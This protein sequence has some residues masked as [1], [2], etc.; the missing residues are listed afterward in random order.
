MQYGEVHVFPKHS[1]GGNA[2]Y[3]C[4]MQVESTCIVCAHMQITT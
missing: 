2:D 3:L 4:N 1:S